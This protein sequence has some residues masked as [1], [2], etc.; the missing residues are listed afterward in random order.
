MTATQKAFGAS[1]LKFRGSKPPP[2]IDPAAD[3]IDLIRAAWKRVNAR[4]AWLM[5][6]VKRRD[7]DSEITYYVPKEYA[8]QIVVEDE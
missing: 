5:R 2:V 4:N 7:H 3:R 8:D 6:P 1:G